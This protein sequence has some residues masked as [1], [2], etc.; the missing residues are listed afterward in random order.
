VETGGVPE[1]TGETSE[2]V[3]V[4]ATQR[5]A[6]GVIETYDRENETGAVALMTTN[7]VL[8]GLV[9]LVLIC[10]VIVGRTR[11]GP[12]RIAAMERQRTNTAVEER[13]DIPLPDD[14]PD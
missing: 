6:T 8:A 2:R 4:A 11:R 1:A 13:L 9:V 10:A 12:G 7:V 14:R 5:A 3:T